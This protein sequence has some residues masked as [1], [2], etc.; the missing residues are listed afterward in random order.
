MLDFDNFQGDATRDIRHS[1]VRRNHRLRDC[2][3]DELLSRQQPL[4]VP[5]AGRMDFVLPSINF[6]SPCIQRGNHIAFD[7]S[8]HGN[9]FQ[10]R[11]RRN[12]LG[13][14]FSQRLNRRQ[15]YAQPSERARTRSHRECVNLLLVEVVLGQKCPN[16]RHKLRGKRPAG[17]CDN[18][19]CIAS[20]IRLAPCQRDAAVL[21]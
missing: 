8:R 7:A 13:Q 3:L 5:F 14:H 1:F 16:L 18:F 17:E 10:Q 4:A 19:E 6:F 2:C 12:R 15:S 11:N 20:P 21:S 9:R